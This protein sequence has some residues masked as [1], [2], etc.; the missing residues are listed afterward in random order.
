MITVMKN[1]WAI[2]LD[3]QNTDCATKKYN[4]CHSNIINIEGIFQIHINKQI[5]SGNLQLL[6]TFNKNFFTFTICTYQNTS[7][8][9]T[10]VNITQYLHD[11]GFI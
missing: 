7:Y 4:R 5:Y 9:G 8:F 3:I 2:I 1:F 6:L 11:H 10:T